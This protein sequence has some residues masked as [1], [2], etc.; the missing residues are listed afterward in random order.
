MAEQPRELNRQISTACVPKAKKIVA[1]FINRWETRSTKKTFTGDSFGKLR[2]Y[3]APPCITYLLDNPTAEGS[4]NETA[5]VL[6]SFYNQKGMQ[7]DDALLALSEWSEKRC[8]PPMDRHELEMVINSAY[9]K[10]Y[11]FGCNGVKRVSEC[12]KSRCNLVR[13]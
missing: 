6:A 12:D 3:E 5:V 13:R 8:D 2:N 4:R 10:G 9:K 1:N 7:H 11:H